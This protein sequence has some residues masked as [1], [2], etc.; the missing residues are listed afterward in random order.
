MSLKYL[1]QSLNVFK[2][3]WNKANVFFPILYENLQTHRKVEK[4]NMCSL[5][6]FYD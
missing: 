6:R 2:K 3:T 5:P 1:T 4:M